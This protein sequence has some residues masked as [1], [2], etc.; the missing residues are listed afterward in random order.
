MWRLSVNDRFLAFPKPEEKEETSDEED[1][2]M[3]EEE[4]GN[5]EEITE[6]MIDVKDILNLYASADILSKGISYIFSY[7]SSARTISQAL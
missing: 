5:Y 3:D 1:E 2:M 6:Q 4:G 7:K